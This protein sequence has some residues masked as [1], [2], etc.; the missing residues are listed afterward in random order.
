[1]SHDLAPPRL[2]SRPL[3]L[4][5]VCLVIVALGLLLYGQTF[6]YGYVGLDDETLIEHDHAFLEHLSLLPQAFTRDVFGNTGEPS[7]YYRPLLTISLMLD[8]QLTGLDLTAFRVTNLGLHLVSACLLLYLL[9][10]LG[11][12][13]E[14]A[15][16]L[17]IL[18]TVHPIQV[19]AVAL[20]SGRND[21]LLAV[22]TLSGL[23]LLVRFVRTGSPLALGLHVLC[24]ALALFT[25]ESALALLLVQPLLMGLVLGEDLRSGKSR[26]LAA[27][28]L[29][30][31]AAY[32]TLRSAAL[33][34]AR[35]GI[36]LGYFVANLPT[37]PQL[38]G[39][40]LFPFNLSKFPTIQDMGF[41]Y[42]ALGVAVVLVALVASRGA[43]W[44]RVIFGGAWFFAFLLPSLTVGALPSFEHRMYLPL[45]GFLLA[46][47]ETAPLARAD[48]R[49]PAVAAIALAVIVGCSAI[50]FVRCR[51]FRDFD[52]FW[53]SALARSPHSRL[54][55]LF[56]GSN[57][58]ER[59]RVDEAIDV[60]QTYLQ[61]DPNAPQIHYRLGV[62]YAAEGRL[63]AAQDAFE[64]E[65]RV[66]PG[67][68][69]TRYAL[70]LLYQ[71][72]G[73]SDQAET[74]WRQLIEDQPGYAKAYQ[75]LLIFYRARGDRAKA[76]EIGDEMRR[77][78][79]AEP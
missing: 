59:G 78:G 62:V 79:I 37:L 3:F 41:V 71:R 47:S 74:T 4:P 72:T 61:R 66:D 65:L 42:A 56:Y 15:A 48:L 16:F 51:S 22:F 60:F 58:A 45:M 23:L 6:S 49:R 8:T 69:E 35:P 64:A 27:A 57:L 33:P 13:R 7:P 53:T 39:K 32:L 75:S 68:P 77:R 76:R 18:F 40:I 26:A 14:L 73:R 30:V 67:D 5:A 43:R 24:F 21:P 46:A 1:M 10:A 52:T 38:V 55:Y 9:V 44:R 20:I 17:A 50:S 28:W 11:T 70:G 29:V 34:Q 2:S 19:L 54:A 12:R 31:L 36:G 63:G 25:K